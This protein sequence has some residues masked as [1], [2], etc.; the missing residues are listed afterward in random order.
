MIFNFILEAATM[1][2][3]RTKFIIAVL[4]FLGSVTQI[5]LNALAD[6]EQRIG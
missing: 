6:I 3:V 2:K 5:P 4:I 1:I